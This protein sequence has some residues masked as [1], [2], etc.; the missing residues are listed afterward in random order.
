M[1]RG[2]IGEPLVGGLGLQAIPDLDRDDA[3]VPHTRA[4][5]RSACPASGKNI[6]PA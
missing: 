6:S 5:S 2:D 4:I 3:L 1:A